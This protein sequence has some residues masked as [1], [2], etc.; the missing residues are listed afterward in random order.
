MTRLL[1]RQFATGVVTAGAGV[2]TAGVVALGE[3]LDCE[4]TDVAA[5]GVATVVFG[6]SDSSSFSASAR[7]RWYPST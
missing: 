6:G 2:V 4:Q 3:A 7:Q 5:A 1:A